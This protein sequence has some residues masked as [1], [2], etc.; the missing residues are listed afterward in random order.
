MNSVAKLG[1]LQTLANGL[2]SRSAIVLADVCLSLLVGGRAQLR[3]K[4]T[5]QLE[6]FVGF[7]QL[8]NRA[9]QVLGP[10][11]IVIAR[12]VEYSCVNLM[13]TGPISES[14]DHAASI[15]CNQL[16]ADPK[17]RVFLPCAHNVAVP[18]G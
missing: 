11:A 5:C 1:H 6:D 14:L 15:G 2:D 8:L 12:T 18:P 3:R 9:L 7:P 4:S 10:D 17:R 16:N 13:P